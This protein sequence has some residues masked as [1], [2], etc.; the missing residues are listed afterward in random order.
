MFKDS[1]R[2]II[3]GI[4]GFHILITC[5]SFY[6]FFSD[7]TSLN[8]YHVSPFAVL[9]YTLLWTGIYFK[10]RMAGLGYFVL[11]LYELAMHLFFKG[12]TFGDVFGNI[13]FPLNLV[14]LSALMLLY[15]SHFNTVEHESN[16]N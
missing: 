3:G 5:Y 11:I 8:I 10:K 9:L 13:L 12:T 7:F 16:S 14:F 4:L 6:V 1:T 15:K 2:W